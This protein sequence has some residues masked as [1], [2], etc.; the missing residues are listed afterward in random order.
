MNDSKK[1]PPA[2]P[3]SPSPSLRPVIVTLLFL[4]LFYLF[5]NI[6]P[7]QQSSFE[8]PY[9]QFKSLVKQQRVAEVTLHGNVAEG[10]LFDPEPMGPNN[11]ASKLFHTR[12]PEFGD[13]SLLPD[14]E[15]KGVK[16]NVGTPAGTATRAP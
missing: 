15:A 7:K 1:T 12:I 4:F 2:P 6:A 9:S 13:Q 10:K 5:F 14:L 16:V 8:I 11:T 3:D